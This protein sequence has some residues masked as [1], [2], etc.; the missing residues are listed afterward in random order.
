MI[1][2]KYLV[3]CC[4]IESILNLLENVKVDVLGFSRSSLSLHVP[5]SLFQP[6]IVSDIVSIA[7]C[8]CDKNVVRLSYYIVHPIMTLS[9]Y[10]IHIIEL[11]LTVHVMVLLLIHF[12]N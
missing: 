7:K 11:I 10:F 1:V 4:A 9:F 6:R 2:S 12:V 8:T 3:Y 5:M